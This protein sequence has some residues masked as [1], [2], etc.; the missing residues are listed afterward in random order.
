MIKVALDLMGG[1]LGLQATLPGLS[2]YI[3]KYHPEDV[4]FILFGKK[5]L[6]EKF[7]SDI[8]NNTIEIYDTEDKVVSN[9]EKPAHA[10]RNSSGSSMYEAISSV[11]N[12][13]SD[14]V[15][16]SGNTGVY[17]ALSKILIGTLDGISR[18]ALVNLLPTEQGKTV[19]LDLGANIECSA[20]KLYQFGIMGNAVAKAL[21]NID[22]PKVGILNIGTEKIKGTEVLEEAYELLSR[23]KSI[24]FCG[25]IEGA[26]ITK[27]AIDVVVTDGFSGNIALKT[28]EG[29]VKLVIKLLKN[30]VKSSLFSS[31]CYKLLYK[32]IFDSLKNKINPS[33][34][35][36]APFVGLNRTVV[37]S[38]GNAD[39][40]GFAHAI[41]TG[42]SLVRSKFIDNIK[43][44]LENI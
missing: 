10:I 42:V 1:D 21:L 12:N 37:K 22:N 38:H 30:E 29:S 2:S 36:G 43:Q 32:S 7:L 11:A 16:S 8:D 20:E 25:F 40:H 18:P 14:V 4:Q 41:H 31:L 3:S 24:N 33:N 35:N 23:S 19:M 5:I 28:M 26:D 15:I 9:N 34:Y 39:A 17:M 44:S 13:K 27:G 6:V